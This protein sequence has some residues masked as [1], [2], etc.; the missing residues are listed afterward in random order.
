MQ[1]GIASILRMLLLTSCFINSQALVFP[2]PVPFPDTVDIVDERPVVFHFTAVHA[3][4]AF[5]VKDRSRAKRE[6]QRFQQGSNPF[7][8]LVGFAYPLQ[9]FGPYFMKQEVKSNI[10][11][12][13]AIPY[14]IR[15]RKTYDTQHR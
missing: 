14:C 12:I 6:S 15:K 9:Q 13:E 7:V 11:R 2:F 1:Y 10:R 8:F 5:S 4:R 3:E